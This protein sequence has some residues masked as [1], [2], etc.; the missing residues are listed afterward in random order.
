MSRQ[1]M[2]GRWCVRCGRTSPT[3]YL[4]K[5]VQWRIKAGLDVRS[6]LDLGCGNGRN[7][8]YVAEQFPE[9]ELMGV[10]MCVEQARKLCP[11]AQYTADKLDEAQLPS[12]TFDLV[13]A[14]YSLMFLTP[15]CAEATVK[16]VSRRLHVGGW[17]VVELYPAKDSFCKTGKE[18]GYLLRRI[19][20]VGVENRMA[21]V[22]SSKDKI[23][24]EVV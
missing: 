2:L 3:P 23:I 13:L 5:A 4:V 7:L 19:E 24:L 15:E 1:H 17:F 10:D 8:R 11:K 22:R 12:G 16:R 9:A 18:C 20:Q 14:N 21:P 6:C